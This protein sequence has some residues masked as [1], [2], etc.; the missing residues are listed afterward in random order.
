MNISE[1]QDGAKSKNNLKCIMY[2]HLDKN[3]SDLKKSSY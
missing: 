2:I 1:V 3:L